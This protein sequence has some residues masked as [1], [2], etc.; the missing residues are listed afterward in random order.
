MPQNRNYERK[1]IRFKLR[2]R[3]GQVT[4]K[5][6]PNEDPVGLGLQHL[7]LKRQIS[8]LLG[9][10]VIEARIQYPGKGYDAFMG[11]IQIVRFRLNMADGGYRSNLIEIV[12]WP[13]CFNGADSPFSCYGHKPT[14]FDAPSVGYGGIKWE[15]HTWLAEIPDA[16]MGRTIR[17]V[18]GFSWGYFREKE[19]PELARLNVLNV[20]NWK[21]DVKVLERSCRKWKFAGR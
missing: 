10:P 4:V 1:V 17:P 13:Q 11:W 8:G 3:N 18:L 19:G 9:F 16:V 5:Y 20:D 14:F 2:D 6:G 12:D 15:A 7:N 21:E